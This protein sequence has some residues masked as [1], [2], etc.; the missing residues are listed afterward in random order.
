MLVLAM[1]ASSDQEEV[2][3][4]SAL[5]A[6][7]VL[8]VPRVRS[9]INGEFE[10]AQ[11]WEDNQKLFKQAWREY[12]AKYPQLYTFDDNFEAKFIEP[13]LYA[14]VDAIS[15]VDHASV[16]ADFEAPLRALFTQPVPGVFRLKMF[17]DEFLNYFKKEIKYLGASG[18]PQRR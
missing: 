17:T 10:G 15:S 9:T 1:C 14:A 4:G 3:I 8:Q 16:G 18:I 12:G 5:A 6:A 11:F 7:R 2:G 13:R